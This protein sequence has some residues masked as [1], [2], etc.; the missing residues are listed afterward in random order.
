MFPFSFHGDDAGSNP[1]GDA[2][3]RLYGRTS[4]LCLIRGYANEHYA[5][6]SSFN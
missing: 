2:N 4:S 1:A 6:T 5:T 3:S